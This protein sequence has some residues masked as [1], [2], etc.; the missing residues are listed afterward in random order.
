MLISA[1]A[2]GINS[3]IRIIPRAVLSHLIYVYSQF[4]FLEIRIT[5]T[6][7]VMSHEIEKELRA[8]QV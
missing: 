7:V 4:I 6:R 5:T 2:Q 3:L 8:L 1:D